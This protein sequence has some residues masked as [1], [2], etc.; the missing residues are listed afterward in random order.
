MQDHQTSTVS[1][2]AAG[3]EDLAGVEAF[4]APFVEGGRILPRTSDELTDLLRTGF[5]AEIDGRIVGF[6]ALEVYSRK[7][8]EIRSLCVDPALQGQGIGRR[9]AQACVDLARERNVFEVMVI[10]SS[11]SFFRGCGFDFTLP[12]EKKALFLQTRDEH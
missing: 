6:A 1:I 4:I 7:L 9:L 12:G 10:T 3:A 11:E 8:A 2:R 5:L